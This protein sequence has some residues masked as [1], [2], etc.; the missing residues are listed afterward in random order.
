MKF[1][2]S[3][4]LSV[5]LCVNSTLAQGSWLAALPIDHPLYSE[6][7]PLPAGH[8]QDSTLEGTALPELGFAHGHE[9]TAA[10]LPY[11]ASASAA[12][13]WSRTSSPTVGRRWF[14]RTGSCTLEHSEGDGSTGVGNSGPETIILPIIGDVGELRQLRFEEN[15]AYNTKSVTGEVVHARA[16]SGGG[17]GPC[18]ARGYFGLTRTPHGVSG[19]VSSSDG[20]YSI[21]PISDSISVMYEGVVPPGIDESGCNACDSGAGTIEFDSPT[22]EVATNFPIEALHICTV[23]RTK[24][25]KWNLA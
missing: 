25:T 18:L 13:Y 2:L 9:L 12:R 8:D 3:V 15:S 17:D 4:C 21:A 7:A 22:D 19:W 14:V 20:Q 23:E 5:C 10:Q 24:N 6:R 16:T 11:A 1:C